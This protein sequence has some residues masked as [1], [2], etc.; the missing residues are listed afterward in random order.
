MSDLTQD[1]LTVLMIAAGGESMIAIARW[2][3]PIESLIQ[4]GYMV[5]QGS[6][7]FNCVITEAGRQ[8]CAGQEQQDEADFVNAF[9][10]VAKATPPVKRCP[11][12]GGEFDG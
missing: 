8:A 7:N 10:K 12:C 5:P 2:K 1:E 11:H 9:R 4:K 6:D 3:Q